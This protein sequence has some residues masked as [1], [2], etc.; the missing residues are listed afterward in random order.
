MVAT[1]TTKKTRVRKATPKPPPR[2]R[3]AVKAP[4]VHD[5]EAMA[6]FANKLTGAADAAPTVFV[7]PPYVAPLKTA[8]AALSLAIIAAQGG[9][10]AAQSALV[11]ATTKVL[12]LIGAHAAWVQVGADA[13]PS[14]DAISYI[15]TAGLQVAKRAQRIPL[16]APELT[17]GAPTVVHFELPPT[18]GAIM[19]FTEI[20]VDGGKTFVRSVDTEHLKGD[21]TGLTSGQS[22]NVRVRAY[23]RGRGYTTWTVLPIVVT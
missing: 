13:L 12:Q 5:A 14:A 19:W 7:S 10:D 4:P 11:T 21:I 8:S 16:S 17:N 15:T 18:P 2:V 1:T 6:T 22:I 23:V 20:S 9:P 3:V